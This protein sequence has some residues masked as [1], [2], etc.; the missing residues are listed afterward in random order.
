MK[1]DHIDWAKVWNSAKCGLLQE[2]VR[3]SACNI[4]GPFL[5]QCSSSV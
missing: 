1:K 2:K 5:V 4:C 3:F